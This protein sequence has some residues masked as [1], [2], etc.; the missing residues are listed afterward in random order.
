MFSKFKSKTNKQL[1][2]GSTEIKTTELNVLLEEV[3]FAKTKYDIKFQKLD[4]K[5]KQESENDKN[6]ADI[7]RKRSIKRLSETK[8][9]EAVQLQQNER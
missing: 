7:V 5:K 2:A 8:K 3:L 4:G 9:Q 1:K 6:Y